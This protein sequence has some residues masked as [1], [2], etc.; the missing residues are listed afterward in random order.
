MHNS[1]ESLFNACIDLDCVKKIA[2][3]LVLAVLALA[4]LT[5]S[6]RATEGK[7]SA[8]AGEDF[9]SAA[10]AQ[11]GKTYQNGTLNASDPSDYYYFTSLSDENLNI[12]FSYSFKPASTSGLF[13]SLYSPYHKV[14]KDRLLLA[15]FNGPG[16]SGF[17]FLDFS[18]G[19]NGSR[20]MSEF[21]NS[22]F[23]LVF[24]TDITGP[25]YMDYTFDLI[26]KFQA[27]PDHDAPD[28]AHAEPLNATTVID[29][30]LGYWDDAD[31]Y[32]VSLAPGH[33]L[34]LTISNTGLPTKGGVTLDIYH[35]GTSMVSNKTL[36]PG[37]KFELTNTTP[38][39][40][41]VLINAQSGT[42]R[43]VPANYSLGLQVSNFTGP[44]TPIDDDVDDDIDDDIVD[45]DSG[46]DDDT[47]SFVGGW[48]FYAILASVAILLILIVVIIVVLVTRSKK[49]TKKLPPPPVPG[50]NAPDTKKKRP[51]FCPECGAKIIPGDKFCG[52][53]GKSF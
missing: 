36:T 17:G 20:E 1:S 19:C 42:D 52:E 25:G 45:D 40:Y 33:R 31:A 37:T 11:T 14:L 35:N 22:T 47:S 46:N 3:F 18:L 48:T 4:S 53:C 39:Y 16:T 13:I 43:Y 50:V 2:I 44:I 26:A 8:D 7:Y 30:T 23:Y 51:K 24:S 32:N 28:K 15:S 6:V 21:D 49:G 38:G 10:L 34:N 27:E 9:F 41:L 12:S 29:G 5:G